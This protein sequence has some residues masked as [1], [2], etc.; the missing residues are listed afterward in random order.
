MA[1]QMKEAEGERKRR[2][3]KR[4]EQRELARDEAILIMQ[5]MDFTPRSMEYFDGKKREVL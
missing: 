4:E 3:K 5:T 1:A 2:E